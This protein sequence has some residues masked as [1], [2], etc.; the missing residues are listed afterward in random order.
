M[1]HHSIQHKIFALL[2]VTG[3][4]V[5][6]ASLFT[7]QKQQSELLNKRLNKISKFW[8]IIILIQLIP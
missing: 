3:I 2:I 5:L 7:G 4:L 1:R 8:L 6:G